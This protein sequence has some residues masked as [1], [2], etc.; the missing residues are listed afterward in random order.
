MQTIRTWLFVLT[1]C[2]GICGR[3]FAAEADVWQ[4]DVV[5]PD[6]QLVTQLQRVPLFD[7]K[8]G[9]SVDLGKLMSH[10]TPIVRL[11][12]ATAVVQSKQEHLYDQIL[13]LCCDDWPYVANTALELLTRVNDKN[14][15]RFWG[16]IKAIKQ[17]VVWTGR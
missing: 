4:P 8:V 16:F 15:N 2:W 3:S 17:S 11:A 10:D 6:W 9:D 1:C 7:K 5:D 12:A 14:R 13:E